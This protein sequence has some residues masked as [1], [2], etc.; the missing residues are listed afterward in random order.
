MEMVHHDVRYGWRM[1]LQ[2]PGAAV[3]IVLMLA[4]GHWSEHGGVH[5]SERS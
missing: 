5:S 2:K 1:L 4:F 3:V